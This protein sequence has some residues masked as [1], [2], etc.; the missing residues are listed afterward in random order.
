MDW[1]K[2]VE[3]FVKSDAPDLSTTIGCKADLLRQF[4]DVEIEAMATVVHSSQR[5]G[6]KRGHCIG[7][8]PND[9][10]ERVPAPK[11]YKTSGS[12]EDKTFFVGD[13]TGV[14][15][16]EGKDHDRYTEAVV[17]GGHY[18]AQSQVPYAVGLRSRLAQVNS[19]YM[20]TTS[21]KCGSSRIRVDSVRWPASIVC[22]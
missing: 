3:S 16:V 6:V 5:R 13:P 17:Q 15:K 12:D 1:E 2:V 22:F 8:S 9:T 19:S 11:R 14:V 10:Q 18:V 4:S 21:C 20:K 7:Q